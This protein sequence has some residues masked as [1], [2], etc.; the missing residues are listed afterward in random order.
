MKT[1]INGNDD[2][3]PLLADG[4]PSPELIGDNFPQP[5]A[6]D[7]ESE[8]HWLH[9]NETRE[10][11]AE[12]EG[13]GDEDTVAPELAARDDAGEADDVALEPAPAVAYY[14]GSTFDEHVATAGPEQTLPQLTQQAL[15]SLLDELTA[16][17]VTLDDF[18][19]KVDDRAREKEWLGRHTEI[20]LSIYRAKLDRTGKC[21]FN[22]DENGVLLD[23]PVKFRLAREAGARIS[24]RVHRGL[25]EAKKSNFILLA[26]GRD[27]ERTE[28]ENRELK[29]RIILAS[30]L[31]GLTYE[32]IAELAGVHPNTARNVEKRAANDPNS[33]LVDTKR[34]RRLTWSTAE[35]VAEAHRLRAEEKKNNSQIAKALGTTPATIGK[36]FKDRGPQADA[37]I[38]E[39]PNPTPE[40]APDQS[41]PTPS[42]V[43]TTR[44]PDDG[45]P[46][47]VRLHLEHRGLRGVLAAKEYAKLLK[48]QQDEARE[49]VEGLAKQ[50]DQLL[51]SFL[52]HRE[53][54]AFAEA[55]LEKQLLAAG[56]GGAA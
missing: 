1:Q 4:R 23:D 52:Y 2:A 28:A 13:H 33:K 32:A 56:N 19:C 46:N 36:L 42:D 5:V 50:K 45:I 37:K 9:D 29:R 49:R 6:S 12:G 25:S 31:Q 26:Q 8:G 14:A 54:A 7:G 16:K 43:D 18:E 35:N 48:P 3:G 38:K 30:L 22:V 34:D 24:L 41:S 27:R 10:V 55:E 40:T 44:V 51:Q 20:S 47:V 53:A 15:G 11:A 21:T 17:H 39:E